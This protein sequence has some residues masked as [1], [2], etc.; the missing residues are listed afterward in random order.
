MELIKHKQKPTDTQRAEKILSYIAL[1]LLIYMPFSLFLGRWLSLYTGGLGPWDAVKD[2]VTLIGLALAVYIAI[3]KRL[4]REP[5]FAWVFW[6]SVAYGLLHLVFIIFNPELHLRSFIVAT[7]YNGRILAYLF[8]GMTA[9][10]YIKKRFSLDKVVKIILIVST[11]TV[12]FALAQYVLPK[13]LMM[14]F[15]YGFERGAKPN[16]FIDD[17]LDLPRVFSTIRDPNSYGA[18]LII[19][20]VL[21]WQAL[22]GRRKLFNR[23]LQLGMFG[24][25]GL[26][27]ILTFSRGAWLGAIISLALA[28]YLM[29]K[30][31]IYRVTKKYAPYIAIGL[32]VAAG[33]ALAVRNTYVF[34]NVVFHSDESTVLADPNELRLQLWEDSVQK[35]IDRPQGHG[36]GTAGQVSIGNPK[37]TLLN[38]NYYLQIAHELGVAGLA[39]FITILTVVYQQARKDSTLLGRTVTASFWGYAFIALLVHVWGNEAVAAQWWLL[40]G[41]VVAHHHPPITKPVKIHK[42]NKET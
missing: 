32:L 9:A 27:L 15:G 12:L 37:G 38:E 25:H 30:H 42:S 28:T 16:F 5:L 7:L 14:H 41:L 1:G 34:Q 29:Y 33:G 18:F 22:L 36:P 3:K 10:G 19:P 40:A 2:I 39:I 31:H 21:L 17:K 11:I 20:L 13:D 35:I 8:I 26:A 23:Q 6:L 24:L 4:L